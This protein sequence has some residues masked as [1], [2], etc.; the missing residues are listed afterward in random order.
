MTT[1]DHCHKP[2]V[3]VPSAEERANK[4]GYP[5]QFYRNLFTMHA[6]CTLALRRQQTQDLLMRS[7]PCCKTNPC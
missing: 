1:C 2:I 3:L 5:A 4:T 7:T 6:D